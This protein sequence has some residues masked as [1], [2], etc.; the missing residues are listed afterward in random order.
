M[1]TR[2][3]EPGHDADPT[4]SQLDELLDAARAPGTPR[5]LSREEHA[6]VLFQQAQRRRE[7]RDRRP[8][9]S[10]RRSL[11]ALV[12]TGGIVAVTTGGLAFAASGH[13]PWSQ[14][15]APPAIVRHTAGTSRM[16]P[17]SGVQ[18]PQR[19]FWLVTQR[20][21]AGTAVSACSLR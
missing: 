15:A 9:R 4:R 18:D 11:Q 10:P 3:S 19:P 14:P 12:A 16:V 17:S 5:E 6:V 1:F 13:A 2:K 21:L 7:E 8:G 20:T